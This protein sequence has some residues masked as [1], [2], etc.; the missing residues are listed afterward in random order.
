MAAV[1]PRTR[2]VVRA[3]SVR[4]TVT[5]ASAVRTT[6][7][8]SLCPWMR[9]K[10]EVIASFDPRSRMIVSPATRTNLPSTVVKQQIVVAGRESSCRVTCNGTAD[11]MR[12]SLPFRMDPSA[13]IGW[14]TTHAWDQTASAIA[15]VPRRVR[16]ERDMRASTKTICGTAGCHSIASRPSAPE[17]DPVRLKTN[18][19]RIA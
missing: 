2:A 10:S 19:G 14:C 12:T 5:S 8:I 17:H 1:S 7:R 13:G 9:L 16:A 11:R 4:R 15:I 6:V 18:G 3:G